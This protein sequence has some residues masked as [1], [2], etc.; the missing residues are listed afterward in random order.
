[1][2]KK[3]GEI[4]LLCVCIGIMAAGVIGRS[5]YQNR[6]EFRREQAR[7]AFGLA[8]QE[9]LAKWKPVKVYHRGGFGVRKLSD[10]SIGANIGKEPKKVL[11]KDGEDK[12]KI[13]EIPYEKYS[14]N[15]GWNSDKLRGMHTYLLHEVP[16]NA[17]SLNLFWQNQLAEWGLSGRTV[18]RITTTDWEE[19]DSYTYSA[20]TL[21]LSASDSLSTYYIGYRCEVGVTGYFYNSW[22]ETLSWKDKVLLLAMI[23]G[24]TL[25]FFLK[26]F[27]GGVFH[28]LFVKEKL[29]VV[30][31]EVPVIVGHESGSHIYQLEEGVYF[32]ADSR[33]LKKGNIIM[34]L[35]PQPAL[36]LQGLLDAENH[37]LSNDELLHLLWPDGEGT[38]V[39]LHQAVKR[40][41]NS[42]SQI[43]V[44]T[45]VNENF[46]YRLKIP[47]SVDESLV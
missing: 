15:I 1:M 42:L 18:V 23:V 7:N 2:K 26:N 34:E 8:L 36:L 30:E 3:D 5:L 14:Q 24:C 16:L 10:S 27:M 12:E 28:R 25:L 45:I 43:S 9:E 21:Y 41:R 40:L 38:L 37:R 35:N 22:W 39:R 31:K 4:L 20:D 19:H 44:C 17:D 29:I 33:L 46:V 47:H 32:D 6:L 11:M 13:F